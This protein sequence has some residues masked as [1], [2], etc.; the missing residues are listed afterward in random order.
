MAG[1]PA[2]HLHGDP[3]PAAYLR[4]FRP[5]RKAFRP[6]LLK[7][8]LGWFGGVFGTKVPGL[9]TNGSG[10]R[11]AAV[12]RWYQEPHAGPDGPEGERTSMSEINVR[13]PWRG[14]SDGAWRDGVAVRD[15]IQA[16]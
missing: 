4:E 13:D 1:S 8:R 15:F 2:L 3:R 11:N 12:R 14:F 9:V 16:N 6:A 7:A 10:H 5:P